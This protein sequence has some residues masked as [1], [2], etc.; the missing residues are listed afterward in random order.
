MNIL[1]VSTSDNRGGAAIAAY[2]LM[3]ALKS[4]GVNIKMAVIDKRS[5]N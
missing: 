5:N 3:N 4:E 1:I 2:R